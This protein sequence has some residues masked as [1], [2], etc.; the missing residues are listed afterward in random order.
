MNTRG[1][2]GRARVAG[3]DIMRVIAIL[4]VVSIHVLMV[5][6]GS[7]SVA[8]FPAVLDASLHFAVPLFFFV[9]GA[10]V[11]GRTRAR[12]LMEYGHFLAG[13]A[14]GVF[15][16]YLAWSVFYLM[17]SAA[18]GDALH[19]L[20]RSPALLLWGRAW[21]HLYF[22]PALSLFYVLTPVLAPVVRRRPEAAVVAAYLVRIVAVGFL[23]AP[24]QAFGVPLFYSFFVT[25]TTHLS[26]VVL[27][28]WFAIRADVLLPQL[29]RWWSLILVAGTA[30]IG[31]GTLPT[32]PW[33]LP[34]LIARS[35]VPLGMGLDVLGIAGLA[36]RTRLGNRG[37]REAAR[38]GTLT[39]GVYLMHPAMVLAWNTAAEA[40]GLNSLWEQPWFP[41]IAVVAISAAS[42]SLSS[43][44]AN[45]SH[46]AWIIGVR[47]ASAAPRP[48]SPLPPDEPLAALV[49]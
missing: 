32:L 35:L 6:R 45:N 31:V 48:R 3:Y 9:S 14:R 34:G 10:L 18:R 21:Y 33:G 42:F 29:K 15:V 30:L 22:V 7:A 28:A 37:E 13:R 20:G 40:L 16:P 49:A 44:L 38:L 11:W 2:V 47:S 24:V 8:L 4:A 39:F 41:L 36:F 19:V 26:D 23:Y 12:S 1:P 46:T 43:A 27:G 25:V 17:V 5:Y